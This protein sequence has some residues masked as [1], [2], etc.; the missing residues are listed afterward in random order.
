MKNQPPANHEVFMNQPYSFVKNQMMAS[1]KCRNRNISDPHRM[2]LHCHS[3]GL[4]V[5][6]VTEYPNIRNSRFNGSNILVFSFRASAFLYKQ[7]AI[8]PDPRVLCVGN[9]AG[10]YMVSLFSNFCCE[11]FL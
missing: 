2:V 7:Y 6:Q 1:S 8:V 3:R 9:H 10:I 4:S 11:G 5:S